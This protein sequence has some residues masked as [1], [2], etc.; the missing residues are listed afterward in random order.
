MHRGEADL[1][2]Q[3]PKI[4]AKY[5]KVRVFLNLS[6]GL[7]QRNIVK[8]ICMKSSGDRNLRVEN[9][10]EEAGVKRKTITQRNVIGV[11][12]KNP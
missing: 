8:I 12:I 6:T 5:L 2:I 9:V 4:Y 10:E 1:R 3:S 11:S 7:R